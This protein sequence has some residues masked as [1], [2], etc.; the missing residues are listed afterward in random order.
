M[1]NKDKVFKFIEGSTSGVVELESLLTSIPAM[2]PE[3]EGIGEVEKSKA[4]EAW[5]RKRG[6]IGRA[7]CRERVFVHV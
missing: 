5:L 1:T 2:A 7:S 6:K 4:L 3:S